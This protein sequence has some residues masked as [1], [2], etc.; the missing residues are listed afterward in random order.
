MKNKLINAVLLGSGLVI[1]VIAIALRANQSSQA[2]ASNGYPAPNELLKATSSWCDQQK[3]LSDSQPAQSKPI[4]SEDEYKQCIAA[5][6]AAPQSKSLKPLMTPIPTRPFVETRLRRLAGDGI[7]I[8]GLFGGFDPQSF[9]QTNTW[10]EKQGDRF[11]YAYGGIKRDASPDRT[12]SAVALLVSD[13]AGKWLSEGG[14]YEAPIQAGELTILDARGTLITLTTPDGNLLFFDV[15]SRKYMTP[16]ANIMASSAKRDSGNG[17]LVETKSSPFAASYIISNH[18]YQDDN[19][20]RL[21]VFAGRTSGSAGQAVVLVTTTTGDPRSSDQ[22]EVYTIPGYSASDT[23]Y[24]RIFDVS[25]N[26]VILVG[27]RG[28]EYVFDLSTKMFLSSAEIA[29]I[30]NDP[31]LLQL[32]AYFQ[33]VRMESQTSGNS[34]ETPTPQSSPAYP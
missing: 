3:T 8:E 32:E 31:N 10:Y 18:W 16:D 30:P 34:T 7:L 27:K 9:L 15:A 22:P 19:G 26:K 11:I 25:Q 28:G 17:L 29:Q 2:T 4:M 23:N 13:L 6:T 14:V 20:K 21:S 1:L 12:H 24:L 33:K 5:L